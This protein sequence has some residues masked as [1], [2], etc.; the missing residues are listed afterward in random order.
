MSITAM[1]QALEALE[2]NLQ[3]L[4]AG[5]TFDATT[6]AIT[7]LRQAI[8][9]AGE[10]EPVAWTMAGEVTNWARDFSKY[11]TKHYVRPVYT[12]PPAQPLT[13]ADIEACM[14]KAYATAQGRQLEHAFARAIEAHI[15]GA[16]L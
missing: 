13:D 6:E 9:Q 1:R 7:A 4:V 12:H 10:Q 2:K 5:V 16:S 3:S 11:K 14:K 8:E 15:K